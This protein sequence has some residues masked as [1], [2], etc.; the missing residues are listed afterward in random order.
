MKDMKKLRVGFICLGGRGS[1]VCSDTFADMVD[2]DVEI[3][4][5]CDSFEDRVD[6]IADKLV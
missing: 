5:I 2:M 1:G 3:A 4:A 6:T